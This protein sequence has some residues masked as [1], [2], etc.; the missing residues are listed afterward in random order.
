MLEA[1]EPKS[2]LASPLITESKRQS[3]FSKKSTFLK[4]KFATN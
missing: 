4:S 2:P 1:R 3:I